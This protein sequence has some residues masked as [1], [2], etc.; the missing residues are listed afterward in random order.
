MQLRARRSV[1]GAA[2]GWEVCACHHAA[3]GPYG[4]DFPS[5]LDSKS[6]RHTALALLLFILKRALKTIDFC[7][8]SEA[9]QGPGVY[10]AAMMEDFVR[11]FRE[12][13]SKVGLGPGV[14]GACPGLSVGRPRSAP[15]WEAVSGAQVDA[16]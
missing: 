5:Q 14:G 15:S 1:P 2:P 11:L 7:L 12:A 4:F 6:V 13:L 10:T 9:W 3:Q 16:K 8:S